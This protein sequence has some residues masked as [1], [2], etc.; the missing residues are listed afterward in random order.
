VA[1]LDVQ[2]TADSEKLP[3][4]AVAHW[5][6]GVLVKEHDPDIYVKSTWQKHILHSEPVMYGKLFSCLVPGTFFVRERGEEI[7]VRIIQRNKTTLALQADEIGRIQPKIFGVDTFT[8]I[9]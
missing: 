3:Y 6:L 1:V 4:A 7:A 8:L 2:V 9:F 5:I